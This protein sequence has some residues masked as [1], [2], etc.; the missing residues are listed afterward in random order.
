MQ[1]LKH[2]HA[3]VTVWIPKAE[4]EELDRRVLSS[5]LPRW[6]PRRPRTKADL[7]REAVSKFL[8]PKEPPTRAKLEAAAKGKKAIA[9]DPFAFYVH[10]RRKGTEHASSCGLS[11]LADEALTS[12][13]PNA[14]CPQCLRIVRNNEHAL[15]KAE[16][17][18]STK[19]ASKKAP[20]RRA[21]R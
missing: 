9:A 4:I 13:A 1:S 14:T 18:R 2:T 20:K 11:G 15:A 17:A 8:A 12:H 19:R 6:D 7:V 3:P 5:P 16:T 10:H 21:R